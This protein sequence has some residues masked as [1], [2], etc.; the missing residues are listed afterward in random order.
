MATIQSAPKSKMTNSEL[1]NFCQLIINYLSSSNFSV[2]KFNNE[3]NLLKDKHKQ[4]DNSINKI[5]KTSYWTKAKI[6]KEKINKSRVGFMS[7]VFG[8]TSSED[9]PTKEAANVVYPLMKKYTKMSR[10]KYNDLLKF[11]LTLVTECESNG[12]KTEIETLKLTKRVTAL[13]TLYNDAM[14]L[15]SD[16]IDD[17][18]LNKRLRKSTITRAELCDAYDKIVKRLNALAIIDGDEEYLELFA[19]WNALIDRYRN[20]IASRLGANKVGKTDDGES[21]Q[22]DPSS[23]A[24]G[25]GG[26]DD[27]PVIE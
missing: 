5:S 15:E 8:E 9:L 10:M 3:F 24:Q 17:E 19:W 20:V 4:F 13:R 11:L 22:H 12:Y 6:L 18:G 26:E 27:R 2:L 25:G 7:L 1:L 23:G 21:S 16:L 14:K